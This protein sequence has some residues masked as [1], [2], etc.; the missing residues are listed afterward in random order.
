MKELKRFGV[1]IEKELQA[2]FDSHIKEKGY[3][4]RSEA[5]RD[6]IREEL[7]KKEIEGDKEI[8]GVITIVYNHH[9]RELVNRIT[10]IQHDFY[11]N[12][13]GSLHIHLDDDNCLEIIAVKGVVLD[14][15]KLANKLKATKGI[16]HT[17]LSM[18]TK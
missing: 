5:I 15:K 7:I 2:K 10:D 11:H 16:K 13:I 8:A 6:L 4:N 9:Q 14:I 17:T 3:T 12:I 18:T 1:S